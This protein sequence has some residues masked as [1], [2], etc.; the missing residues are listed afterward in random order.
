[1]SI[2]QCCAR[3]GISRSLFY[4]IR[5]GNRAV[6]DKVWLKLEAAERAAGVGAADPPPKSGGTSG[7][8]VRESEVDYRVEKKPPIFP[9]RLDE[10][11]AMLAGC[12][13]ELA[14]L[15][16]EPPDF[17]LES[18]IFW[19]KQAQAW[20]P[21]EDDEKLSPGQLWKKYGPT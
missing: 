7:F 2:V 12:Q 13:E 21:N 11:A 8:V 9:T 19:M 5:D 14:A 1:M 20:P 10:I 15:A 4:E 16:A 3:A 18:L 6:S 17:S